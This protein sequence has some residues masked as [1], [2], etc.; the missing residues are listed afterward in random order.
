VQKKGDFQTIHAQ[1]TQVFWHQNLQTLRPNWLHV[2]YES[3]WGRTD[4]AWHSIGQQ[5]KPSDR[6]EKKD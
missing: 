5:L 6:T 1:E 3:T 4:N 2:R